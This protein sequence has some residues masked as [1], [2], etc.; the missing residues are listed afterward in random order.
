MGLPA[1]LCIPNLQSHTSQLINESLLHP[2]H[3][4]GFLTVWYTS[5]VLLG[6]ISS[7]LGEFTLFKV[8][9]HTVD[10]FIV[11]LNDKFIVERAYV[12]PVLCTNYFVKG[13]SRYSREI[14]PYRHHD[15]RKIDPFVPVIWGNYSVSQYF[16]HTALINAQSLISCLLCR[17]HLLRVRESWK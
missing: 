13:E 16:E 17:I 8:Q 3:S 4:I 10:L 1:D 6:R 14:T 2:L 15:H 7:P 12:A 9:I 5:S 11:C